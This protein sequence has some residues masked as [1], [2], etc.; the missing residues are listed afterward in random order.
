[1][2]N[3]KQ[4]FQEMLTIIYKAYRRLMTLI[5]ERVKEKSFYHTME[6]KE[7][8]DVVKVFH[9]H[10]KKKMPADMVAAKSFWFSS[11]FQIAFRF[12]FCCDFC[13]AA[14]LVMKIT[15]KPNCREGLHMSLMFIS[16]L[17][18]LV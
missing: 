9:I 8:K 10:G 13:L 11:H 5:L 3:F 15:A 14:T 1:M 4:P 7:N 18:V 6:Q 2:C 12:H 16:F 17:T